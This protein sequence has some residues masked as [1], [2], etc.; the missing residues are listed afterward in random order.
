MGY[1]RSP[2]TTNERRGYYG[3]LEDM[4]DAEMRYRIR[5]KRTPRMLPDA[6]DDVSTTIVRSW[7][8]HR[9]T[10]YKVKKT[11]NKKDSSKFTEHA[12]RKLDPHVR[13]RY[14]WN[15]C[16][17]CRRARLEEIKLHREEWAR[18][19]EEKQEQRERDNIRFWNKLKR[20]GFDPYDMIDSDWN[21]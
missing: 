1:F 3:S 15:M 12:R 18:K 19:E 11:A 17:Q 21:E 13:C 10:Q 4:E 7:K 5:G 16:S 8:K 6:W 14:L 20:M 2:A 9:K